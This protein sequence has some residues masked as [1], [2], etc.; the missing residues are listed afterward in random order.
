MNPTED[1]RKYVAGQLAK[2]AETHTPKTLD[3]KSRRIKSKPLATP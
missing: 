3:I 1:A 2:R